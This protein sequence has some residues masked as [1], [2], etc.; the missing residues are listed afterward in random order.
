[1]GPLPHWSE[2]WPSQPV[3]KQLTPSHLPPFFLGQWAYGP[4]VSL[5]WI[6]IDL[7]ITLWYHSHAMLWQYF[8]CTFRASK[9]NCSNL[10]K[11]KRSNGHPVQFSFHSL[12]LRAVL[13][14]KMVFVRPCSGFCSQTQCCSRHSYNSAVLGS[15]LFLIPFPPIKNTQLS[16]FLQNILALWSRQAL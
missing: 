11:I 6:Q 12:P 1:M 3:D 16:R 13:V 2:N 5:S 4:D 7:E 10:R 15:L 8:H 14:C 9:P